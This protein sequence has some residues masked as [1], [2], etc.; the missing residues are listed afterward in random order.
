MS[1]RTIL[2]ALALVP[3]L[4]LVAL[5]ATDSAQQYGEWREVHDRQGSTERFTEPLLGVISAAQTER[6]LTSMALSAPRADRSELTRQRGL[7]DTAVRRLDALSGSV[8][9]D[10]GETFRK[11]D[12]AMRRLPD[13]RD[14][15]DQG[16]ADPDQTFDDYT[17]IITWDLELSEGFSNVGFGEQAELSRP[18]FDAA[19]GLEMIAREDAIIASG[20]ASGRLTDD[21]R[22]QLAGAIGAQAHIYDD[23]IVAEL[24]APLAKSYESVFSSAD[25]K[26]K[27]RTETGL[28]STEKEDEAGRTPVAASVG[29]QWQQI[30][31]DIT[32]EL[33]KAGDAVAS[34][35]DAVTN[36]ELDGLVRTLII[37]AATSAAA[38]LLLLLF[39]LRLTGILRLRIF[40]LRS[41]ALELQTRLPDMVERLR[42]GEK[43][44]TDAEL[45][46]IHHADDE[47]GQLG[48]ALNQA[49]GSSLETA[50][51]E[52]ELYRGF[53]RLLQRIARRTQLLIGMQLRRLGEMQREHEDPAVL[54]G[55]FD[56]DHLAARLRRY[57][58]NL[59]ILGNG[60]P[61]RRW[62]RPVLLLDVL[63][64]AQSEVQDY[65]RIRI[66]I[67]GEAW[68]SERAV[69]P[70]AHVLAE[71]MEN[72]V[73]FSKPPTPVEVTVSQVGRGVAIEIE[74]RGMGMEPA[75]YDAA[76]ALMAEPPR[77]DVMSR[78]DD[79]RLGLY[80][81]A[82]LS[83]NLGLKVELRPS[84][85]GGTRVVVLVPGEL[86]TDGGPL[87]AEIP[88]DAFHAYPDQ[89]A[90]HSTPV[91]ADTHPDPRPRLRPGDREEFTR[92]LV[93]PWIEPQVRPAPTPAP[94][95]APAP[96]PRQA[97]DPLPRRVRQASL[98]TEL[99][100]PPPARP[101]ASYTDPADAQ[102]LP[103]LPRRN[104]ARPGATVGAFQRQSRAAR[105][106]HTPDHQPDDPAPG[107]ER[108]RKE[109]GR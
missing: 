96:A 21:Q 60:Q 2:F 1:L 93:G 67:D 70:V 72:A 43:V 107:P 32:P 27:V 103:P 51:R 98:A 57:E 9:E 68:L 46:E 35:L 53:E 44:D 23:K 77:M 39:T 52:V 105:L 20:V 30:R 11:L 106:R 92:P 85:F 55:L 19:W 26:E 66:D 56:L 8:P 33:E 58:E 74:D 47:L 3:C 38:V 69:G 108:T 109:D 71:L 94:A 101:E 45:P 42:R 99:R 63:R 79:A 59:V 61:Q 81:V 54:E 82:R 86:I 95:P 14:A 80:V 84:S 89:L 97:N 83:A 88:A 6:R 10:L 22:F 28:L 37:T 73:S 62:R 49:R 87:P 102:P 13:Q 75:Q 5:A 90:L 78:A 4:V 18:T 91:Q 104:G 64:S 24:P 25:W 40:A 65:R 15:V 100:Q 29:E 12:Q 41:E 36:G 34:G 76:N 50:V 7:T 16:S 31:T 48:Q 17:E